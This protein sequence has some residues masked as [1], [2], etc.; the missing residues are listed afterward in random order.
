MAFTDLQK[1]K[2][3][4][5]LGFPNI[6]T[7]SNP[8]LESAIELFGNDVAGQAETE[9]ILAKLADID[10]RLTSIALD[11]AGISSAGQGDPEFFQGSVQSE[12]RSAG[13]MW[14]GRLST[15]FGI[16]VVNDVYGNAGYTG[17]GWSGSAFQY[18]IPW[19]I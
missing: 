11:V 16:T 6:H 4:F 15:L 8:R 3:R 7:Q 10:S 18:G 2:I 17:D 9:D 5:Y 12:L 14:V 13:R 19:G 1:T